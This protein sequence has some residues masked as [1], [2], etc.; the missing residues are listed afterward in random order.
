MDVL[1]RSGC[2]DTRDYRP[3]K[4]FT[5]GATEIIIVNPQ[6]SFWSRS[7]YL[8]F[9]WKGKYYY[10]LLMLQVKPILEIYLAKTESRVAGSR[11]FV[12][13]T[14]PYKSVVSTTVR[15]MFLGAMQAAAIDISK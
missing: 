3:R 1:R 5:S 11:L 13:L 4:T 9:F 15:N 14:K 10:L 6:W 12:S 8:Y 7:E 2:G